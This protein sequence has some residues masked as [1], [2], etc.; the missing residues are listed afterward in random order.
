MAVFVIFVSRKDTGWARIVHNPF[1]EGRTISEV[2]LPLLGSNGITETV[3]WMV[4]IP[5][6]VQ[7]DDNFVPSTHTEIYF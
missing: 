3:D 1:N 5:S 6:A 2:L 7:E 4:F